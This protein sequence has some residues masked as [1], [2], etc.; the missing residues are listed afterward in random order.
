MIQ[1]SSTHVAKSET[2]MEMGLGAL[3]S[4]SAVEA[5]ITTEIADLTFASIPYK[6]LPTFHIPLYRRSPN[7]T[8]TF[9]SASLRRVL[10]RFR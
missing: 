7:E 5:G 6:L 1:R 8:P 3:Y 9:T 2:L 4:E 10:A